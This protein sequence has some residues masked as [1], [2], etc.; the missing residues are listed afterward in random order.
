MM[1]S[2]TLKNRTF[3]PD[4]V[5]EEPRRRNGFHFHPGLCI[6][7]LLLLCALAISV[8]ESATLTVAFESPGDVIF[9]DPM[10]QTFR[11]T[12]TGAPLN[13][14]LTEDAEDYTTPR[15]YFI[16]Q[17]GALVQRFTLRFQ[18]VGCNSEA[19]AESIVIYNFGVRQDVEITSRE[20]GSIEFV[21]SHEAI[22]SWAFSQSLIIYFSSGIQGILPEPTW[23][24]LAFN[25][26]EPY[27]I[28]ASEINTGPLDRWFR[29]VGYV[30]PE[31][32]KDGGPMPESIYRE[33]KPVTG[34]TVAIEGERLLF[35]PSQVSTDSDGNFGVF[36]H[37]APSE[38][39]PSKATAGGH[40][41]TAQQ[42]TMGQL[43]LKYKNIMK[44]QNITGNFCEVIM[45]EGTVRI[46]EGTG[47]VTLGD[48]LYPGQRLSL[49]ASWGQ[50][51][52]IGLRFVNGTNAS[53][54]QD[55]FTNACLAD[56]ITIGND[57]IENDSVIQGNTPLMSLS[58][59]LC[60]QVAGLPNTPEE[61]ARATGKVVVKSTA[62]ALVPGSGLVG[63][64]VKYTVKTAAGKIYDKVVNSGSSSKKS[65][66]GM[67]YAAQSDMSGD[68]RL[69]MS[70]YYDGS[71]RL[72][73]NLAVPV[74]VFS[75]GSSTPQASVAAGQ[76][77]EF[78]DS[79]STG[80]QWSQTP[81]SIDKEGPELRFSYDYITAAG[82]YNLDLRAF[83]PAGINAASLRI[84]ID[85][86]D[87]TAEFIEQG[88]GSNLWRAGF[89][90]S[91]YD[92]VN[93]QLADN[94]GNLSV[95]TWSRATQ[96]GPPI[97]TKVIPGYPGGRTRIEWTPPD[98]MNPE[99]VLYY[100]YRQFGGFPEDISWYSVGINTVALIPVPSLFPGQSFRLELRLC[101][102]QGRVGEF[103]STANLYPSPRPAALWFAY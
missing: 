85:D 15:Y 94:L 66:T 22:V 27:E 75:A 89:G 102:R 91:Y 36:A 53:V 56:M 5:V 42:Q 96:P 14:Y 68:P 20:E 77:Q 80:R 10:T 62:S 47:T 2:T 6:S 64:A 32:F 63:F 54:V 3:M 67:M 69:E 23:G 34:E 82:S 18:L 46:V 35:S 84:E 97:L 11:R 30:W 19:P 59:T 12:S 76:W 41:P 98:G 90:I 71:S 93:I 48:I 61:W 1:L 52:Q 9:P 79:G 4:R 29:L 55:V 73:H 16:P 28:E 37:V 65:T 83:D 51:A 101:D 24:R 8:A 72:I 70:V 49:G 60:E 21:Y 50:K 7:L 78:Q 45:L 92:V 86:A 40:I 13:A 44:Q 99:D 74:V 33:T 38:F 31:E 87:R 57:G 58:R 100:E 25:F 43:R 103:V 88:P 81:D 26:S 95:L 39:Y 17:D